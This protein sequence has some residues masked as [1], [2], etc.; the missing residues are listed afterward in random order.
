MVSSVLRFFLCSFLV[1]FANTFVGSDIP[2]AQADE[3]RTF[4]DPVERQ[5]EGWTVVM[6]PE[7]L[8]EEHQE[9]GEAA[10]KALAN[11]LQR[12]RYILDDDKVKQMQDL[13]IWIDRDHSLSN[14]QYHPSR[15][16]LVNHGHDPRLAKHVHIPR[17]SQ[18]L[19]RSQWA[20]HPYVVLHELAHAYHDQKLGFDNPEIARMYDQAKS[21]GIYDDVLLFTGRRVK[22]YALTS[23]MEYFAESTEAYLG[24]N[25]FF[26]F[27]RAELKQ[28]DPRMF[29][30]MQRT[31]GKVD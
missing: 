22:H 3:A 23:P 14:M 26:P 17:A 4:Y 10:L 11:H 12:I 1:T 31:W 16:W 24:V 5:V 28:H 8:S 7:L 20:K 18:L 19:N 13:R 15:G 30:L 25:D 29:E 9:E 6:D 21:T 2:T 27:V